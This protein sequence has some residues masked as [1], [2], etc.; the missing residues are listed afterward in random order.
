MN[1]CEFKLVLVLIVEGDTV[2]VNIT[3]DGGF[4]RRTFKEVNDQIEDP[5]L[6]AVNT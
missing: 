6:K 4:P 5:V 2:F 3:H 1:R